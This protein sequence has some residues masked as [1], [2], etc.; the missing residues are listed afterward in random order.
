MAFFLLRTAPKERIVGCG[1]I[2][3]ASAC[4]KPPS[5]RL[6]LPLAIAAA[7]VLVGME[8]DLPVVV[9]LQGGED[10]PG[11][12]RGRPEFPPR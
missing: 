4:P 7:A 5:Q 12:A 11:I 1:P 3:H 2:G 6:R 8:G 9:R 10:A